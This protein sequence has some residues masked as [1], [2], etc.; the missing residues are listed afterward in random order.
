M[1]EIQAKVDKRFQPAVF[2][3]IPFQ[4]VIDLQIGQILFKTFFV[5]VITRKSP[6]LSYRSTVY[7]IGFML[8][9]LLF[10]SLILSHSLT[11]LAIQGD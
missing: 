1:I 8:E 7:F 3:D 6:S 9:D 2:N 10:F 5:F 11:S 4:V